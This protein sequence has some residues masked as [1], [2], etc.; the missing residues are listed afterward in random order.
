[1]VTLPPIVQFVIP[2]EYGILA[3]PLPLCAELLHAEQQGLG[4]LLLMSRTIHQ[5]NTFVRG[6]ERSRTLR[7]IRC[8]CQASTTW[9][10]HSLRTSGWENRVAFRFVLTSSTRSIIPNTSPV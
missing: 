5:R 2:M 7:E 3:A 8:S 10:S 1:M 9:T 4:Q 6:W